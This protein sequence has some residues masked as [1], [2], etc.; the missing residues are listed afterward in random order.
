MCA[1]LRGLSQ[2]APT[3]PHGLFFHARQHVRPNFQTPARVSNRSPPHTSA[4]PEIWAAGSKVGEYATNFATE[5]SE[6][7]KVAAGGDPALIKVQFGKLGRSC[8]AC[9]D[10]FKTKD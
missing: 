3:Y 5:A 8:K 2:N 6:L 4:K 10:D 1:V 7:A 9:H